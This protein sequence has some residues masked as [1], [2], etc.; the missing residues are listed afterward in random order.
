MNS[1]FASSRLPGVSL[2]VRILIMLGVLLGFVVSFQ[3]DYNISRFL[4]GF[5]IPVSIGS[6]F[7]R[8]ASIDDGFYLSRLNQLFEDNQIF[9]LLA[10]CPNDHFLAASHRSPRPSNHL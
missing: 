5:D 4:P 9:T 2:L 3:G 6:L 1:P 10:P 8:I 7:Q